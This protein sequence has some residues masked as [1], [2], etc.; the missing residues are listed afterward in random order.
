V[1]TVFIVFQALGIAIN[2]T[3]PDVGMELT[4]QFTLPV[5]SKLTMLKI[6]AIRVAKRVRE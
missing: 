1:L 3:E 6:T 4:S 5:L 2:Q